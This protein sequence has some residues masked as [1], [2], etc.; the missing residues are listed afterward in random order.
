MPPLLHKRRC[1]KRDNERRRHHATE[2]APARPS[3]AEQIIY[4]PND[5]YTAIA[6]DGSD[7]PIFP[8]IVACCCLHAMPIPATYEEP[9]W[10]ALRLAANC[11][12]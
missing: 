11:G 2:T 6:T 7:A 1:V 8:A 9:Q 12:R 10:R 4:T 3:N 5:C